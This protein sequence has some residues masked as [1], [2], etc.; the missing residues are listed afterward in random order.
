MPLLLVL[1]FVV[2]PILE[3]FVIIQVGDAIGV[4]PTVALLVVGSILGSVLMRSQGRAA[5]RD[6]RA[7]TAAGKVPAGEV[8]DGALIIFGGALLLT[9][10]FVTDLLGLALL[11]PPARAVLRRVLVGGVAKRMVGPAAIPAGM[12]YRAAAKHRSARRDGSG[13]SPRGP[14]G[15]A[16]GPRDDVV[17]GTAR[18][19]DPRRL[20]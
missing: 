12:A 15:S 16:T 1:L 8:L 3:L 6:F 18:D 11:L 10:G 19:V 14:S 5:W 17:D 2:V 4:L 7:A 13:G 9:P 20:P